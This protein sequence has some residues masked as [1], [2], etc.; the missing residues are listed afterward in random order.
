MFLYKLRGDLY[1]AS[2]SDYYSEAQRG[3]AKSGILV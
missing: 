1:S 3:V 2:S